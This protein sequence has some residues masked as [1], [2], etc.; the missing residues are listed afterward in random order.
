VAERST[1]GRWKVAL[2]PASWPKLLV[3]FALGQAIGIDA[4]GRFS[5]AGLLF[6]LAFTAADAVFVVTLNDFG[7]RQVDAIKRRM[8]PRT[9]PKTI[10][11]GILPAISLL[12]AG[13]IAGGAALVV[14]VAAHVLLGRALAV[15]L[16]LLALGLFVAYSLPP[17]RLNYRGGGELLEM[18]GVGV[19]LP[20]LSAYL[21]SGEVWM[22]ALDALPAAAIYALSSAIASGLSDERSDREGGKRTFVTMLGST[23]ARRLIV[24]TAALA[25]LAWLAAVAIPHGTPTIPLLV[26]AALGGLAW[27]G[28]RRASESATTDAFDAHARLK[29]ALHRAIWESQLVLAGFLAFGPLLGL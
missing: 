3:P 12:F 19:V 4:T 27:P 8:F 24:L 5:L 21:Q 15:P 17:I 14:G 7:D 26:A 9:S 10:P 11:D 29:S 20:W 25:P 23:L 22:P 13:V 28:I 18:L 16:V 6:A 2:K 1:L